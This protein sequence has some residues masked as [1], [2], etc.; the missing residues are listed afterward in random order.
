[1]SLGLPLPESTFLLSDKGG[2]TLDSSTLTSVL[3]SELAACRGRAAG[4]GI[5]VVGS[6]SESDTL[7]IIGMA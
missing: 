1:M 4:H 3:A 7:G 5:C 6:G 2:R